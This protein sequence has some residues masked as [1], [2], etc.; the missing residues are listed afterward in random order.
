MLRVLL[1]SVSLL[2]C[3]V[4]DAK[5]D[6]VSYKQLLAYNVEG[7]SKLT[8]GMTKEQ[9]IAVMKNYSADVHGTILNNPYKSEVSQRGSNTYEVM[10]YLTHQHPPFT[11]IRDAQNTPVVLKNG[12][13]VGWG[14]SALQ[15]L[16]Q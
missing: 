15:S 8:V 4:V 5:D 1:L 6:Q 2:L 13:V 12:V 9:V 16:G 10:Y 3:G 11:P 7:I 14:K